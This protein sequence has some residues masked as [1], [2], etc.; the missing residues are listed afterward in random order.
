MRV[1]PVSGSC[2]ERREGEGISVRFSQVSGLACL[3]RG[4]FAEDKTHGSALQDEQV[5]T[6]RVG[7]GGRDGMAVFRAEE[8]GAVASLRN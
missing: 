1:L 8:G 4:S 2:G 5:Q 7:S 6:S 3:D